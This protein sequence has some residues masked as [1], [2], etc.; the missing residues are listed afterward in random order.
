[1]TRSRISPRKI[2]AWR[3]AVAG[4]LVVLQVAYPA[5]AAAQTVI[6]PDGRTQTGVANAGTVWDVST[7]TVRGSNAFNSFSG[8]SVGAGNTVNLHVPSVAANLINIVRD[9]R[10]DVHGILNAIKDGRVGG[11]V[12]FANPNGF[13]VGAGGVVNVGS[14]TVVTPT[15]RFV[16]DFFLAPGSPDEGSVAQLLSGTAPRNGSGLVLIQGAVNVADGVTLS[17]GAI[18]V[19]GSIFSGARFVGAAPEFTDVVN[20]NGLASANNVVVREGKVQIVADND[21]TVSGTIAAPGG[22]GVRGGDIGIR[23][24]GNVALDAGTN[25]SARGNG[26]NSSGGTVN[27]WADN[28]AIARKGSLVD[29]SAGAIG[30]G[31]FVEFSAKNTVELAG[32]EFRADGMGGGKAGSVL[33]DPTNIVVSAD[34]LRGAGGYGALP[35]GAAAAGANLTL[36]ADEAITV[37][38]GVTISTRSV[39]GTAAADHASAASTGNSGSLSLEAATIS[40]KSGSKLLAGANAG[41]TGGDV[42]LKATR[43]W[44]GEAKVSVDNAT[45]TGRNVSLTANATYDDSILTS[46]LPVVVPVTVSTIDVTSGTINASGTLNLAATSLIDVNSTGLS[47]LGMITA[48]SAAS[49]DVRGASVLTA[50]GDTTLASSSTVKAKAAPGGPN[51]VTLP[52]DAGVAI[53]VVVSTAKTRVGDTSAVTVSGGALDL[54]AKNAVNATTTADST[55]G[56]AVAVGGTLALSEVTSVT[57]A[58]IDGS[59]TTSSS[60]LKVGAESTSIVTTSAKAASKGAKKQSAAEKAVAPS[61]TEK[62][63]TKYKD[64]TTTPDGSVDVAAA[65]AIANVNNI[66]LADI[67]S[68]GMQTSIGAATVSSKA[69]STSTVTADGSSASGTVG[70]GAAVG[71]NLGVLVNQARVADNA[72]VSSNGLTVSAVMPTADGKNSFVTTATSGAGA[73]NVG[74]AG[75]LGTNVLVNTTVAA[76]EG[77]KDSSGSGAAVNANGGDVLVESANASES[78]LTVGASVKP[79]SATEPAAVG[80]GASVGINVGVNTT[81]AEVGNGATITGANDLGLTAKGSHALANDVTGGAAGADVSVTPVVAATVAVN[82]TTA[83]LGTGSQLNLLGAYTSS[84]EQTSSSATTATGQTQGNNV[85]VGASIA[86]NNATDT[87]TAEIDRDIAAGGDV[88]VAAKSIAMSS[89]TATAS[90]AGGEK[91]TAADA[92]PAKPDGSAGKTVDEK[93]T[94]QGDAAKVA[95]KKTAETAAASS[96]T[97][98]GLAAAAAS[99]DPDT[100]KAAE[101]ATAN[102]PASA[103]LAVAA[104]TSDSK[105]KVDQTKAPPTTEEKNDDGTGKGGGV[106]VAA[107]AQIL[108]SMTFHRAIR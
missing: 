106:A 1:M 67:A 83:R 88:E 105:T 44:T 41:F 11:N 48:V 74:V 97:A 60:A 92:P 4:L 2:S 9:Q 89:A 107:A 33:I 76:V 104:A 58:I 86:L 49:V 55:A 15:Q 70:V 18:N 50:A 59:A 51:P 16:D 64:Q 93:V 12:W 56:G 87:V 3:R 99:S 53:D 30:D 78:K 19:A 84:A 100:K 35:G 46:W 68:T 102:S 65:V 40:L 66:T 75:A 101:A 103:G 39:A 20:A 24:G 77:D 21:V 91:A 73:S 54:T 52:G 27:I 61:E 96:P 85:A 47:P 14:L 8:F 79:A 37:N 98:A 29:A 90:V 31:G 13:L 5:V 82:T 81:V 57:Q 62:T 34:I 45:I 108:W 7:G 26:V 42:T 43:N 80:V 32:G 38:D 23:A 10:T 94:A 25:I 28:N 63:L 36:L 95:G 72:S 69:S 17:A 6:L 22:N 71:V